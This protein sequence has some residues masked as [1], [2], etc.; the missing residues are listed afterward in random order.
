M[1]PPE[2][3]SGTSLLTNS[4]VTRPTIVFKLSDTKDMSEAAVWGKM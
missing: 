2:C 3:T 1:V 4:A